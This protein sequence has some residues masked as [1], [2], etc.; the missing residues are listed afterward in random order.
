MSP[1]SDAATVSALD[2]IFMTHPHPMKDGELSEELLTGRAVRTLTFY[3][4]KS[5][6]NEPAKSHKKDAFSR[7]VLSFSLLEVME[8]I[9]LLDIRNLGTIC[10]S[11]QKAIYDGKTH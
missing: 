9:A 1:T 3:E 8:V 10:L 4:P 2:Y 6:T 5:K 11:Y 7:S